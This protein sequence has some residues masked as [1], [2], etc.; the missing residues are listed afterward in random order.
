MAKSHH[1]TVKILFFMLSHQSLIFVSALLSGLGYLPRMCTFISVQS[2][3]GL[4]CF[5]SFISGLT[6]LLNLH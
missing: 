3:L 4:G 5:T 6:P 2:C 1:V